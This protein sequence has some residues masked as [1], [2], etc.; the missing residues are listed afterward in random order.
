MPDH[1]KT[2]KKDCWL[3]GA[4]YMAREYINVLKFLEI[5]FKVVTRGEERA[6]SLAREFEIIVYSGG[7]RGACAEQI[8]LPSHAIVA[9]SVDQLFSVVIELINIGIK[10]ILV[11]KPAG[12]IPEEISELSL[13]ASRNGISLFVAYNRRFYAS[14]E[15]LKQKVKEDGGITSV[16]FEFTE[17]IHTIDEE[18]FPLTVLSKFV[19]ANSSHVIDTVFHIIGKPKEL[20]CYIDGNDIAWHPS[21]SIFVG[22]GI[23]EQEVLFS[24]SSNWGAPG[25][26]GIE[27]CTTQRKYYLKPLE[28]L[29]VQEKGSVAVIEQDIDYSDDEK[30]KPGLKNMLVAFF[31]DDK[32]CLCNINEHQQNFEYFNKIAG[33][34]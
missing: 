2:E 23:S 5:D 25:R 16:S 21:G 22:C 31:G 32:S 7:V 9:V 8:T 4:G 26:W 15:Y 18:K 13:L 29:A 3:I 27:I 19:I 11:E 20:N 10:N 30:F 28:R 34:L 12:L 14:I 17:W 33:Y 6:L 1:I 24:Y